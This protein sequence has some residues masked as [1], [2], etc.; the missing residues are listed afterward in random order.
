M[1]PHLAAWILAGSLCLLQACAASTAP[2]PDGQDPAKT[3]PRNSL[4]K[5]RET[6]KA[7]LRKLK[8]TSEWKNRAF[9]CAVVP[10]LSGCRHLPDELPPDGRYEDKLS[11]VMTPNEIGH[12]A[13]LLLPFRR[14]SGVRISVSPLRGK[15]SSIPASALDLRIVK[16]WYQD[17]TAWCSYFADPLQQEL[18]PELL[19]HDENLIRVDHERKYNYLR[20]GDSW[21]WIS[22]PEG[23]R[24]GWFNYVKAP[25]RDAG[26]LAA[27]SLDPEENKKFFLT[28]RL[29]DGTLP[30][31]YEGTLKIHRAGRELGILKVAL[32]VLPFELPDPR[33]WYD[34]GKKFYT[35]IYMPPLCEEFRMADG[36]FKLVEK[37]RKAMYRNMR[38][39]NLLYP[40]VNRRN[41]GDL[42][43]AEAEKLFR[44]NLEWMRDC[45]LPADT[46]FGGVGNC[47]WYLVFR[48]P[49]ERPAGYEENF[50][51]DVDRDLATIRSVMGKETE[52]YSIG[53]D[54]PGM[55]LLVGQRPF[56]RK[57]HDRG[58]KIL[59]T[60]KDR[61]LQYGAYNEDFANYA[62]TL[63][64]ESAR[65]WHAMGNRITNYANPHTG[66]ENPDYI[67][68]SHG[69]ALYKADYDGSC[70]Y[71]FLE[72]GA[73]NVW[74]DT[75]SGFRTFAFVYPAAD[76][77]L[78]TLHYEGF[79][80]GI[81]DI[82]YATKLR[83]LAEEAI[84]RKNTDA[85]YAGKKALR[86][87]ALAQ[88]D[89]VNLDTLRMEMIEQILKLRDALSGASRNKER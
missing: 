41:R 11:I 65:I 31:N 55:K 20:V 57:I 52:V 6:R 71:H 19:L 16:Y 86:F 83:L 29:P 61:H 53:W 25:V 89:R 40:L 60:A 21:Q 28:V 87:L 84:A 33:T 45:G 44:K 49:E 69:M 82:R 1:K 50:F 3:L 23:I 80:A 72:N 56:W 51:R 18:V 17:G 43:D 7:F 68:R 58:M 47:D 63:S 32:R 59:S 70:N 14:E 8:N 5:R 12:A 54:E 77:V 66:P 37:R 39:H 85:Y 79:R 9:A 64:P 22:Y 73:G 36:D 75:N 4:E 24:Y 10:P 15:S 62:G 35:S 2:P 48:K 76:G 78:D 13:F 27:F 74:R 81:D 88:A 42:P 38:D 34:I 46:V 30:G 26:K 67:R